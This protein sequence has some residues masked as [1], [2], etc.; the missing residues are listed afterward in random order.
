MPDDV[1]QSDSYRLGRR[2]D[3]ARANGRESLGDTVGRRD[4]E[5]AAATRRV[6]DLEIENRAFGIRR[7]GS[8]VEHRIECRVKQA[9]DKARRRVVAAGC[10]PFVPGS[11]SQ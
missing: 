5:M 6:A 8:F 1:S 11:D 7:S 3:L 2:L 4:Q 9:L 10:L